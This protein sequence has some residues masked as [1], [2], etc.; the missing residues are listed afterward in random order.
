M[1]GGCRGFTIGRNYFDTLNAKAALSPLKKL[2][3]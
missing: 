2:E 1:D 3:A